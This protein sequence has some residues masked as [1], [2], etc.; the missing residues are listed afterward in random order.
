V[1][2][3]RIAIPGSSDFIQLLAYDE[4]DAPKQSRL[5]MAAGV[6]STTVRN[7]LWNC[8]RLWYAWRARS[9]VFAWVSREFATS[10]ERRSACSGHPLYS[11]KFTFL[12]LVP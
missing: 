2:T 10:A 5:R 3:K 9:C 4:A 1:Q 11:T 12:P 7:S 6:S 8:V